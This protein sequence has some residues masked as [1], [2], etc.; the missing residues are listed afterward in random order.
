MLVTLVFAWHVGASVLA[1]GLVGALV[2]WREG[3][4]FERE[5]ETVDKTRRPLLL[6]S[7]RGI[8]RSEEL[9]G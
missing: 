5:E 1:V 6:G 7:R 3:R 2:R 9:E 4:G 8:G